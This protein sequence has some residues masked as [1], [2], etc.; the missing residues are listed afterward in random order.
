MAGWNVSREVA[1][2]PP[3][4]SKVDSTFLSLWIGADTS[5]RWLA[6]VERG[7]AYTG[8]NIEDL[9]TLPVS[10]P[11]MDEQLEIVRRVQALLAIADAIESRRNAAAISVERLKPST[12]ATAF[13]GQLVPQDPND[14]PASEL[15]TRLRAKR[16]TGTAEFPRRRPRTPGTRPNMSSTDKGAIKAAILK[17][18]TDTFSFDELRSQVAGDYESLKTAL[19]ELLAEPTPVVRQVFDKKT[20]TMRLMRVRL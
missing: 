12:L 9:R 15:L 2:V 18:T 13:R 8:I 16:A 14:E 10:I 11:P 1:V 17:L 4:N 3:D 6:K 19:F 5:Q 20:K 7:V